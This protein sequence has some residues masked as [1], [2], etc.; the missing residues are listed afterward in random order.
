MRKRSDAASAIGM[1]SMGGG[2]RGEEKAS[3][4]GRAHVC[5]EPSGRDHRVGSSRG[6]LTQNVRI[7]RGFTP[8]PRPRCSH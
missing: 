4:G 8:S 1:K 5:D 3:H 7:A 6:V 2:E